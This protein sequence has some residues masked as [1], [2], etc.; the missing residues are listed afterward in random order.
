M[1]FNRPSLIDLSPVAAPTPT[2]TACPHQFPKPDPV[3]LPPR[4]GASVWEPRAAGHADP[5]EGGRQAAVAAE[6]RHEPRG[7]RANASRSAPPPPRTKRSDCA[8]LHGGSVGCAEGSQPGAAGFPPVT[9]SGAGSA[10]R[11]EAEWRRARHGA[12]LQERRFSRDFSAWPLGREGRLPQLGVCV[13][14]RRCDTAKPQST[15]SEDG[16]LCGG[17]RS[18]ASQGRGLPPRKLPPDYAA[19]LAAHT[20]PQRQRLRLA[21]I[22]IRDPT[23]SGFRDPVRLPTPSGFR[24][25]SDYFLD[26]ER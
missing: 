1:T 5:P 21:H 17:C 15:P 26:P 4:Q 24:Q 7:T 3:G 13:A 8:G 6:P 18:R 19:Y 11:S 14:L 22:N 9:I 16:S 12:G 2:T 20:K 10:Q 25:A 23:P